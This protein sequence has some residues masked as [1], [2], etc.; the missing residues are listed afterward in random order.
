ML[1]PLLLNILGIKAKISTEFKFDSQHPPHDRAIISDFDNFAINYCGLEGFIFF[2]A[3][4]LFH[5]IVEYLKG[6]LVEVSDYEQI[7]KLVIQDEFFNHPGKI[8]SSKSNCEKYISLFFPL[9]G[10]ESSR[11]NIPIKLV[12]PLENAC[13]FAIRC[14]SNNPNTLIS[15]KSSK[16]QK[17]LLKWH[18]LCPQNNM[19]ANMAPILAARLDFKRNSLN[20]KEIDDKEICK[21]ARTISQ[22]SPTERV[23]KC[24]EL[25][26]IDTADLLCEEVAPYKINFPNWLQPPVDPRTD[27][28]FVF[29]EK[30]MI[31]ERLNHIVK[32]TISSKLPDYCIPEEIFTF[33][34][35]KDMITSNVRH[36]FTGV[37][38]S[39]EEHSLVKNFLMYYVIN[40]GKVPRY[41]F[42]NR[43]RYALDGWLTHKNKFPIMACHNAMYSMGRK[44][45]LQTGSSTGMRNLNSNNKYP[46]LLR[47]FSIFGTYNDN[48]HNFNIKDNDHLLVNCLYKGC[49][50]FIGRSSNLSPIL[51]IRSQNIISTKNLKQSATYLVLFL[52]NFAEKYLF[53]SGK[54]ETID[55]IID[56][57]GISLMNLSLLF[58]IRPILAYWMEE[59]IINMFPLRFHRIFIIQSNEIW[60][61]IKEMLVN[62]WHQE[63]LNNVVVLSNVPQN[64]RNDV[65]LEN[66]KELWKFMSPYQIES[67]IGGTRPKLQNG[68][69]YPFKIAHGPYTSLI[70]TSNITNIM[71]KLSDWPLP[72]TVAIK[73]ILDLFPED[74]F[75]S[76][77]G[78]IHNLEGKETFKWTNDHIN[79]FSDIPH[80]LWP[81]KLL[82][83]Y[84]GIKPDQK[85]A[86]NEESGNVNKL[87][88]KITPLNSEIDKL[89]DI[90]KTTQLNQINTHQIKSYEELSRNISGAFILGDRNLN[91]DA[92]DYFLFINTLNFLTR[93]YTIRMKYSTLTSL[94]S[95]I[96]VDIRLQ[97]LAHFNELMKNLTTRVNKLSFPKWK[98]EKIQETKL[99]LIFNMYNYILVQINRISNE[100]SGKLDTLKSWQQQALKFGDRIERF[101]WAIGL[102]KDKYLPLNI[103]FPRDINLQTYS[104]TDIVKLLVYLQHINNETVT[105]E[106]QLRDVTK[107]IEELC[108]SLNSVP[109]VISSFMN[110]YHC[111]DYFGMVI[112]TH[113]INQTDTLL[114]KM[115]NVL[116]QVELQN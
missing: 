25:I 13:K 92:H 90:N 57:R 44:L 109:E 66:L 95:S 100:S 24:K 38:L 93:I 106:Q 101:R 71:P 86:N 65:E 7:I 89:L 82:E 2:V 43:V 103:E 97:N 33:S 99:K 54:V 74:F 21:I 115:S 16:I 17:F 77:G 18:K 49:A 112:N 28:E 81:P 51:I 37:D 83:F 23:N 42:D 69:F 9:K 62:S 11:S 85:Y 108:S 41:I 36:I 30:T 88:G 22:T 114:K 102:H 61:A 59:G 56:C 12:S 46:Y 94:K 96:C 63:T 55:V 15:N 40:F 5:G 79:L 113:I 58:K 68:E 53:V 52:M 8:V 80:V 50:Y 60:G 45:L 107:S 73:N 26:S 72:N 64:P 47:N 105:K 4:C 70:S 84:E 75:R 3:H 87:G 39:A 32:I 27:E 98:E 67:D 104:K 34:P 111:Y 91:F 19:N 31:D 76:E 78:I 116:E 29:D 6:R 20:L 48:L 14:I 1:F 10:Y 35:T 110:Q